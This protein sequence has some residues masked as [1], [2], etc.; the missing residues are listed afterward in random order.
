[1]GVPF[2]LVYD[3]V[4]KRMHASSALL[5]QYKFVRVQVVEN[6]EANYL[7][8]SPVNIPHL[9]TAK[10]MSNVR[11]AEQAVVALY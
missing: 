3:N 7:M 5:F 2:L 11:L 10:R 6:D 8:W 4:D 9:P 1:V